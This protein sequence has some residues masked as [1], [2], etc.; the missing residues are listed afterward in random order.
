MSEYCRDFAKVANRNHFS[1]LSAVANSSRSV[2]LGLCSVFFGLFSVGALAAPGADA[3]STQVS[4]SNCLRFENTQPLCVF[5]N[6]E[7][8]AVLPDNK[9]LIVSEYGDLYGARPGALVFFD[10]ASQQRRSAFKGGDATKPAEYWGDDSCTEP[11][12]AAF[13]PHGIDLAQRSDGRWQLL[14]VQHGGRESVEFFEVKGTGDELKLVWRGCT[15]APE[16]AKLNAVAAGTSEAF[17]TTKMLSTNSSWQ[18]GG[19]DPNAPTGLVYRW[20]KRSG[21]EPVAG[22]E[23]VM[24][25]GIAAA[26]DGKAVYVVYS[27]ENAL[28]KIDVETGAVLASAP[29]R[30]GDNVKW[31]ADGSTL[32]ASSFVG[33]IDS[34]AFARCMA[35]DVELCPI[36]FAIVELDPETLATAILFEKPGAPMGAG[37]VGLKV[38][39]MLFIG[40]FSGNRILQVDL[41]KPAK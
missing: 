18:S 27:G 29:L 14:V 15:V 17:F 40:S 25:N 26:S 4:A 37:T 32:L 16:N 1:G 10:I 33:L 11:P 7:D 19:G 3:A 20:N 38:D 23:G 36:A 12:G 30:S 24:P 13:S 28:K 39:S 41:S 8:L 21:F 5:S 9:V 2:L 22:T 6:P 35:P 34:G 31:S